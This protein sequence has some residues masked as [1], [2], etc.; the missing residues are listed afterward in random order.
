MVSGR[1]QAGVEINFGGY[2]VSVGPRVSA[3]CLGYGK[4][5]E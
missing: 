4:S 3:S 5:N 2:A 1:A